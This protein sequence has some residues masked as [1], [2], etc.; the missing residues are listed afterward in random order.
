MASAATPLNAWLRRDIA[1]ADASGRCAT[2]GAQR[3]WGL[4]V[5]YAWISPSRL[6]L[7]GLLVAIA[8][9]VL[10]AS[11]TS[12]QALPYAP[13][14]FGRDFPDPTVIR[15]ANAW[16]AYA[17]S[18]AWEPRN[19]LFPVLRS[20]DLRHW[21][22][23]SDA[24][25]KIPPWTD[26][27]WWGPGALEVRGLTY[28]YYSAQTSGHGEHC[29]AL[30][31]SRKPQGPFRDRGPI[32]C[33]SPGSAGYIDPSPFIDVDGS[34]YLFFAT[35]F[36]VH[37]IDV[38]PLHRDLFHPAGPPIELMGVSQ[39]WQEGLSARTVEGPSVVTR[40]GLYYLFYSAGSYS[41][42]YRM[43]YAVAASVRGPYS[44]SP[45]N[46]I[47]QGGALIA[48]GGGSVFA[49]PIGELL[50]FSA[51]QGPAG[52]GRGGRRTLRIAPLGWNRTAVSVHNG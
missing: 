2:T 38:I 6:R 19:H 21:S 40:G 12:A 30:A 46:P 4:T 13:A 47:L 31:I 17:T 33:A 48:P 41:V 25:V 15:S 11:A 26:G 49:G 52:Y 45:L 20:T 50:A 23:V 28:L 8:A 51:W 34:A 9:V 37:T 5:P 29:L 35:D 42:D 14:L 7:R 32:I 10:A 18:T 36:P 43:G 3:G 1:V 27:H 22:F 39:P 24:F 44:D 16:Y